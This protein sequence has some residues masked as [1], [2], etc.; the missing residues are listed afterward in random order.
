MTHQDP[1]A[2]WPRYTAEGRATMIWD[3][4]PRIAAD[5][6]ERVRGLWLD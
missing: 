6:L 1:G 5:P 3:T 4:E 2:D